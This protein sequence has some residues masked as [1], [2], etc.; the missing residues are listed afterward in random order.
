VLSEGYLK[1]QLYAASLADDAGWRPLSVSPSFHLADADVP[2]REG[3]AALSKLIR[4]L[5]REGWTVV[6][7]GKRWYERTLERPRD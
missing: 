7:E 2:N 5:R 4:Q 6:R 3:A 1:Y